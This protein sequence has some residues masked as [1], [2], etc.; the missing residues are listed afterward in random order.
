MSKLKMN[1][2]A[3]TTGFDSEID[4]NDIIVFKVVDFTDEDTDPGYDIE[5]YINDKYQ[6]EFGTSL[7]IDDDT[8]TESIRVLMNLRKELHEIIDRTFLKYTEKVLRG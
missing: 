5:V 7:T 8:K 4:T 1:I 6:E 3:S 2:T